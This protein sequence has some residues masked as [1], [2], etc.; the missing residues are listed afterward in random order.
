MKDT[1]VRLRELVRAELLNVRDRRDIFRRIYSDD[2]TA[3]SADSMAILQRAEAWL[4][5]AESL[6]IK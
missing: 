5:E 2:K 3:A 1:E 6:G 4:A